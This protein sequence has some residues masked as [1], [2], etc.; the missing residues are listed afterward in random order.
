MLQKSNFEVKNIFPSN[1]RLKNEPNFRS[2]NKH[3]LNIHN[4]IFTFFYFSL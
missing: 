2:K 4:N 3:G 1:V